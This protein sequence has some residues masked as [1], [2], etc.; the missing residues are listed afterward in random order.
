MGGWVNGAGAGGGWGTGRVGGRWRWGGSQCSA[1]W[2][3]A[4]SSLPILRCLPLIKPP[5]PSSP[6]PPY[7]PAP[8]DLNLLKH[9]KP[10]AATGAA[11]AAAHLKHLPAYL[12]DPSLQGKSFAGNSGACACVCAWV[13]VC[14]CMHHCMGMYACMCVCTTVCACV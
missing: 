12:R 3:K 10:L 2:A 7:C 5:L 1:A 11:A 13:C 9:D 14:I 4:G 8:A 6:L